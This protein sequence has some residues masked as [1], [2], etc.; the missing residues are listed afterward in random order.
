MVY[1]LYC[2]ACECNTYHFDSGLLCS[3]DGAGHWTRRYCLLFLAIAGC[4]RVSGS[5]LRWCMVFRPLLGL[6]CDAPLTQ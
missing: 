2:T 6:P 1:A 4:L 3:G 5:G